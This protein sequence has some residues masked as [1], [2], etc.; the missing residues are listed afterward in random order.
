MDHNV[1]SRSICLLEQGSGRI[2]WLYRFI[3]CLCQLT[4]LTRDISQVVWRDYKRVQR[5]SVQRLEFHAVN[6]CK[7]QRQ[8]IGLQ[9]SASWLQ[10]NLLVQAGPL[11]PR[12]LRLIFNHRQAWMLHW[13]EWSWCRKDGSAITIG[14]ICGASYRGVHL[15]MISPTEAHFMMW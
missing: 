13:L 7:F 1:H 9:I 11:F 12:E 3:E 10:D 2:L 14:S 15:C 8:Q 5:V 6:C 4:P